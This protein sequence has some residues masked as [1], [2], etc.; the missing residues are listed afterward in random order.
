MDFQHGRKY[1]TDCNSLALPIATTYISM[2]GSYVLAAIFP[3][4]SNGTNGAGCRHFIGNEAEHG[5][6]CY[7]AT[8]FP[9]AHHL[10]LAVIKAVLKSPSP[11]RSSSPSSHSHGAGEDRSQLSVPF[12]LRPW[13]TSL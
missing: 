10:L 4:L 5:F 3:C 1:Q 8:W 6:L 13:K 12:R 11:G 9:S 7:S 2:G